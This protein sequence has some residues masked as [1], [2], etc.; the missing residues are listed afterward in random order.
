MNAGQGMILTKKGSRQNQ[1][2]MAQTHRDALANTHNPSL[3]NNQGD[4]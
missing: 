1:K 3:N 4:F 2:P